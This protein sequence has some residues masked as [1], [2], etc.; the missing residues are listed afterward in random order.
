M[1]TMSIG[2]LFS[3]P[4]KS[5]KSPLIKGYCIKGALKICRI[6][7]NSLKSLQ[8]YVCYPTKNQ[9]HRWDC[10]QVLPNSLTKNTLYIY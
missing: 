2:R 8:I 4:T 7:V 10:S 9:V 5:L 3:H 6:F 1:V